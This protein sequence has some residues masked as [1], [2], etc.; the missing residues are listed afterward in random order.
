MQITNRLKSFLIGT[1]SLA[2]VFILVGCQG[3][4]GYTGEYPELFSVAIN[5]IPNMY[6]SI[7]YEVTTEPLVRYLEKDE[8]GRVL[9]CYSEESGKYIDGKN[10]GKAD[11]GGVN[12]VICQGHDNKYAYYY[13][14]C[15]YI[16]SPLCEGNAIHIYGYVKPPAI[17]KPYNDFTE[18]QI[19]KLKADNDWGK[20]LDFDKCVKVKIVRKKG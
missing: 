15:N 7:S 11:C 8:Y 1:I 20:E 17:D 2:A 5:S 9:F 4:E 13:D 10:Q 3:F 14:G 19:A 12:L 16:S 18:E 6:G